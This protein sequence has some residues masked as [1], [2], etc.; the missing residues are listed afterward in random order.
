MARSATYNGS[1]PVRINKFL[2]DEGICS[3]READRLIEQGQV[4]VDGQLAQ[5]GEKVQPGQTVHLNDRAT[6]QLE[7]KITVMVNKPVGYVSGTPEGDEVPAVRLIR[8]ANLSG[9]SPVI[10]GRDAKLAPLGRL[11]KDSRGL[12]ILSEDGV[13]AKALIGPEAGMEKE[14]VVKVKGQVTPEKLALLRHG[15]ELDGRKLKPAKVEIIS[16][17]ILQFILKEGRN[18]QIRRMCDLVDLRVTDLERVRIGALKL[19]KLREGEWRPIGKREIETLLGGFAPKGGSVARTKSWEEAR[20]KSRSTGGRPGS[21]GGRNRDS[22]EG[23]PSEPPKSHSRTTEKSTRIKR[24]K[25]KPRKRSPI[26]P[27]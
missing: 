15:L 25:L 24:T 1:D 13:L 11:D 8:A 27:S 12:L 2:A 20:P 6:R 26:K 10:P 7:A 14:Y 18:R 5:Q 17:N 4:R 3:R 9:K 21:G 16:G 19:G 22:N 23:G